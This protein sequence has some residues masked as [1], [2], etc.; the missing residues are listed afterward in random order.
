MEL[1]SIEGKLLEQNEIIVDSGF[2]YTL[3]VSKYAAGNYMLRARSGEKDR[4]VQ[5]VISK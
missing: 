4:V 1:L 3:D 5:I 2:V